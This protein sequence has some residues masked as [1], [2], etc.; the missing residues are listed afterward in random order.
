M[1]LWRQANK[2]E[3]KSN[4]RFSSLHTRA[5]A[6]QA[7]SQCAP[8]VVVMC[9]GVRN[10]SQRAECYMLLLP[11]WFKLCLHTYTLEINA[12]VSSVSCAEGVTCWR[13][14]QAHRSLQVL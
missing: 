5:K 4:T 1:T 3:L 9:L 7:V 11:S 14:T 6:P 13:E 10:G 12:Q 8:L 2:E